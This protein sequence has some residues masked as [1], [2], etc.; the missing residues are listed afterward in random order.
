MEW[1]EIAPQWLS[2]T[3]TLVAVLV[4]LFQKSMRDWIKRPKIKISCPDNKKCRV[5]YSSNTENQDSGR[6]L[7]IR[8]KILNEGRNVASHAALYVDSFYKKRSSDDMYIIEEF[9][10]IVIKDFRNTKTMYI[11]PNLDYYYDLF[12]I[13]QY[14]EKVEEGGNRSTKQFY[15]LY[16]VGEGEVQELGKGS[17]VVPLKFYASQNTRAFAYLKVYWNCDDFKVSNEFLDVSIITE[18]EFKELKIAQ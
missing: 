13:H 14:D 17:F 7:K 5:E 6:E 3:G 4:A 1:Y 15:K 2:A 11:V 12:S 18:K 16:L 9:P 10:P 8:V